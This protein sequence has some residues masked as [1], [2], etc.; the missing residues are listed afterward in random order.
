MGA[1]VN[2]QNSEGK[3]PLHEAIIKGKLP[4]VEKLLRNGASVHLKTR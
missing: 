4:I 3:T 2:A 1:D